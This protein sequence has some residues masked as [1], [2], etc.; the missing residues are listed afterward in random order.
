MFPRYDPRLPLSQQR[1]Y[2][3]LSRA[4]NLPPDAVSRTERK[5]AAPHSLN[6]PVAAQAESVNGFELASSE[7]LVHLWDAAN[8]QGS[9]GGIGT[10][11][12]CLRR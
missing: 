6:E 10:V 2:P 11:S 4:P 8:G 3:Q 1:Y 12:L 9:Q 7:E 5:T